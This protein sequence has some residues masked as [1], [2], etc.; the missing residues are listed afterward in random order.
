MGTIFQV[1]TSGTLTTLVSFNGTNGGGNVVVPLTLGNDGNLYGTTRSGGSHNDGTVFQITTNGTLTTLVSF[2]GTNGWAPFGLT[3]GSDGNFYGATPYGG[4]Y[5]E[6]NVFRMTPS[7]TLTTL[8]TF[9]GTNGAYPYGRL[10]QEGVGIFYGTTSSGGSTDNGTVFC[11]TLPAV[12]SVPIISWTNPPSIVY[13]AALTTNQLNATANVPGSF[14]Y[15]PTNGIV[16]NAG[17]NALSVIFIPSD[18]N[19]YNTATNR[20]TLMVSPAPF[21]VTASNA[22]RLYGATNPIF[23][24]TIAGLQNGDNITAIYSTTATANS[25]AGTYAIVPSLVDPSNRQTNYAVSLVNGTLTVF[26]PPQNFTAISM[27]KNQLRLQL[28]GTPN[29]LYILQSAT[30]LTP[31][32]NW[33]PILTNPAD[34]NG[35]WST[36]VTNWKSV[37]SA[38]FRAE[39]Q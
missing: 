9:N 8:A 25:P 31:P 10:V 34:V 30:N 3:L 29:F 35:N 26:L 24:G 36:V 38:F 16:L 39:A 2:D 32:I 18:T 27:N 4:I 11:L 6:G 15:T 7:G 33:Q 23:G 22:S 5:N 1:T 20:V 17:T 28:S 13:G 12:Q 14:A 21:A 37:P 19:D